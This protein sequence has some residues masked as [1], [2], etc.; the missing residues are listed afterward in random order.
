MMITALGNISVA[1]MA[2]NRNFF[3][4]NSKRANP[5]A[6]S[7]QETMMNTV[8]VMTMENVLVKKV[9]KVYSPTPFQPSI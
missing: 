9:V 1:I 6:T 4:G 8:E 3:M 7:R 5:Y 2:V